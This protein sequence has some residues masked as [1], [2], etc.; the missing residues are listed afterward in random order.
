MQLCSHWR[1]VLVPFM[2]LFAFIACLW[3][4]P[5]SAFA[6]DYPQ[7]DNLSE[8]QIKDRFSQIN[9]PML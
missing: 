3:A 2:V 4:M 8:Q 9:S 6:S 5:S 1:T 7:N